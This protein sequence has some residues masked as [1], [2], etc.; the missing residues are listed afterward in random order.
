MR[1]LVIDPVSGRTIIEIGEG[2]AYND[3]EQVLWDERVDGEM[4]SIDI[5]GAVRID[6]DLL[7]NEEVAAEDQKMKAKVVA[8]ENNAKII[9]ELASNDAKSIR[10]ILDGDEARIAEWKQ[11]QAAL[12]M[13]LVKV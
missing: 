6:D 13:K 4:P 5:A 9:A 1:L 11:K 10:A 12:R 7:Y 2:G 3:P 8:L